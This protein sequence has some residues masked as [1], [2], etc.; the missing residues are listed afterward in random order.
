MDSL[1]QTP[2][3]SLW[4]AA[5]TYGLFLCEPYALRTLPESGKS[6][7][8]G[9]ANGCLDMAVISQEAGDITAVMC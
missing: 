2:R 7:K 3:L 4:R 5:E 1:A 9:G 6:G 8:S